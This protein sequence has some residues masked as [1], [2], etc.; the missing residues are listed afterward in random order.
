MSVTFMQSRTAQMPYV[1][2]AY[3][4]VYADSHDEGLVAKSQ[5]D[6]DDLDPRKT[7]LTAAEIKRNEQAAATLLSL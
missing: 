2:V 6:R 7:W 1:Q 3:V 5:G 4:S